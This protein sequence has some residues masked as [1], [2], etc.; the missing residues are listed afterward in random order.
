MDTSY[1]ERIKA[2]LPILTKG[3]QKVAD[4]LLNEPIAFATHP[5]K[6]VGKM[7]G[8]SETMVHR[9]CH[10]IGYR[11]YAELQKE[12]RN[13][14]LNL[15]QSADEKPFSTFHDSI[16]A[17]IENLRRLQKHLDTE[18]LEKVVNTILQSERI[19]VAG[20]YHSFSYAH[21]LYFNLNYI[22]G[23][24]SLFRPESD[25]GVL[26]FLPAK[27]ALIV[28]SFYRYAV[29]TIQLAKDAQQK[30]IKVIVITDSLAAPTVPFADMTLPIHS[31]HS[32]DSL[33]QKGPISISLV[34]A[35]VDEIIRKV[36]DKEN[37]APTFNY[38]IKDVQKDQ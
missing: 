16:E 27:S 25:A 33:L 19:V 20:F 18:Q 2:N 37:K 3:L 22:I 30:G 34:N 17:D 9:F 31:A 35:I 26:D 29:D 23:N 13:N 4:H 10:A 11:G 6:T 15:S 32:G 5:A 21:W 24:V 8:V 38:F 1:Q 36:T 7:I 12:V 28:F 14:L